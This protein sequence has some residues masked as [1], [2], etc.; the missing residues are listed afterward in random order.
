M[1][2]NRKKND[3]KVDVNVLKKERVKNMEERKKYGGKINAEN[4]PWWPNGL[5]HQVSNSS[6]DRFKSR[7]KQIIVVYFDQCLGAAHTKCWSK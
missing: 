3:R 7:S 6:R 1:K 5:S 2:D 4:R